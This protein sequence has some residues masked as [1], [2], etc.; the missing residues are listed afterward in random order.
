MHSEPEDVTVDEI[1][2]VEERVEP[3]LPV[4]MA[5]AGENEI[6]FKLPE[7]RI[8]VRNLKPA[9]FNPILERTLEY[10]TG[11]N[12]RSE[13]ISK[14]EQWAQLDPFLLESIKEIAIFIT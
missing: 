2:L 4:P 9:F 14:M 10:I 1:P 7:I 5:L 3:Q 13:A 8:N 11:E 6:K 12:N